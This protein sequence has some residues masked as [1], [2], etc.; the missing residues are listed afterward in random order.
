M[1]WSRREAITIAYSNALLLHAHSHQ[2]ATR[3][4]NFWMLELIGEE[5]GIA[6]IGDYQFAFISGKFR[7]C[8]GAVDIDFAE[9]FGAMIDRNWL[10]PRSFGSIGVTN[11]NV[12]AKTIRAI[13]GNETLNAGN[14]TNSHFRCG[15]GKEYDGVDCRVQPT[16]SV[17]VGAPRMT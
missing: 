7:M 16:M 8:F 10:S 2:Q 4:V 9:I 12:V 17:W 3:R 13:R 1:L 15:V 14:L 11:D 5:F 6:A